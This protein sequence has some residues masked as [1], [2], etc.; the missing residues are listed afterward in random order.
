MAPNMLNSFDSQQ[1]ANS[2]NELSREVGRVHH[3]VSRLR[4]KLGP[5]P[6]WLLFMIPAASFALLVAFLIVDYAKKDRTPRSER[7]RIEAQSELPEKS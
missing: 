4:D 1:I 5:Q 3:E 7:P 2:I 6:E